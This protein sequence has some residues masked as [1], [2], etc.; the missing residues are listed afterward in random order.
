ME[1]DCGQFGE[2][3]KMKPD[4]CPD[5]HSRK[6]IDDICRRKQITLNVTFPFL[7]T[8]HTLQDLALAD[9][10]CDDRQY[11]YLVWSWACEMSQHVPPRIWMTQEGAEAEWPGKDTRGTA[12][13]TVM[14]P[15]LNELREASKRFYDEGQSRGAFYQ[16]MARVRAM[17]GLVLLLGF[18]ADETDFGLVMR[19][20]R[21]GKGYTQAQ[22]AAK[23]QR[24]WQAL[25]S[26]HGRNG[27][28]IPVISRLENNNLPHDFMFKDV[29]ILAKILECNVAEAAQLFSAYGYLVLKER[30]LEG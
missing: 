16:A 7:L 13:R 18:L 30:C 2:C 5:D 25:D 1:I 9:L 24:Q 8:F 22:L 28:T 10:A 27:L 21:E 11:A 29:E 4:D 15:V 17:E 14:M 6:C 3:D 23:A 19:E 20:I 26:R 12:K